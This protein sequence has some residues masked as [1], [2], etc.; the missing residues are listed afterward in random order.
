[1]S[2]YVYI[3]AEKHFIKFDSLVFVDYDGNR[4]HV[5]NKNFWCSVHDGHL[6]RDGSSESKGASN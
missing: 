4:S 5:F 6:S 2:G 1:M 3:Q